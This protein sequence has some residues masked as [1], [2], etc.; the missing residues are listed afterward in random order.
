[1]PWPLREHFVPTDNF[2]FFFTCHLNP[3]FLEYNRLLLLL[4]TRNWSLLDS[5]STS[6]PPMLFCKCCYTLWQNGGGCSHM[7]SRVNPCHGISWSWCD[8]AFLIGRVSDEGCDDIKAKCAVVGVSKNWLVSW[9]WWCCRGHSDFFLCGWRCL[10][11]A[12]NIK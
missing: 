3:S 7:N 10:L 4:V 11:S 5:I 9:F 2:Y 1:M 12:Y 8:Y 6:T